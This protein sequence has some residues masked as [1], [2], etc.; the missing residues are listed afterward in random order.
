MAKAFSKKRGFSVPVGEWIQHRGDT[1]GA[2]VAAQPGVAELC[3][4]SAVEGLYASTGKRVGFAAWA[5]LFYA[6]WHHAHVLGQSM[7]GDVFET[8]GDS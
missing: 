4:P 6:L 8:L 5:L 7:G 3:E 2:L 1:L